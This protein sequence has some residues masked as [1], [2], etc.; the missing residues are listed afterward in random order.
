MEVAYKKGAV[1]GEDVLSEVKQEPDL[2]GHLRFCHRIT[3]KVTGAELARVI[4][5]WKKL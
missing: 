2:P 1:Y 3:E 5:L 4:T